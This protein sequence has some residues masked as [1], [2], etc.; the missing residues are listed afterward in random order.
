MASEPLRFR[1]GRA[2]LV[3][4]ALAT[5]V[6]GTSAIALA[7]PTAAERETARGLMTQG[8]SQRDAKDY[9]AALQSFQAADAIMRVPTTGYEVAKT[10]ELMGQLVEA[11]DTLVRT[12]RIPSSRAIRRRSRK[13]ARKRK[14]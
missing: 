14:R 12:L 7:E 3:A 5:C 13:R 6:L 10:L 11:R 1:R 4:L 9:R 2:R 8:R